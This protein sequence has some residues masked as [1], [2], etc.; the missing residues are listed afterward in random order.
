[1][2]EDERLNLS[3]G[4]LTRYKTKAGLKEMKCYGDAASVAS[5]TVD[6]EHYHMQDLIKLY[7]YQP[8]DIFNADKTELFYA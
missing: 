3:E 1:M 4:W 7:G 2:P 6:K 8:R 5:E